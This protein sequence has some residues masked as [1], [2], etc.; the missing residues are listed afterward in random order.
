METN[1]N[2]LLEWN[3][4]RKLVAESFE[5]AAQLLMLFHTPVSRVV[6]QYFDCHAI[7]S[8]SS[9]QAFLRWDYS[10]LCWTGSGPSQE[11]DFRYLAFTSIVLLVLFAFTLALPAFFSG[12]LIVKRNELYSPLVMGR[13]GWLYDRLNR[14]CEFWE[15]HEMLRKMMLTGV[16][17]FFPSHPVIRSALAIL[18][19][20]L[21]IVNLNYFKPHRS[22]LVFWTE[23][24]SFALA[25]F[26][27]V[28]AII[29]STDLAPS[30]RES[31]GIISIAVL[32]TFW[33]GMVPV[34][35]G[36]FVILARRLQEPLKQKADAELHSEMERVER[37]LSAMGAAGDT[38]V[39]PVRVGRV[40]SGSQGTHNINRF[41]RLSL[42]AMQR[43][44][45]ERT[46]AS[47]AIS[48]AK[49]VERLDRQRSSA[50]ARLQRRKMN[51]TT[52]SL[53][54]TGKATGTPR[55]ARPGLQRGLTSIALNTGGFGTSV[56]DPDTD[57]D[58]N[59]PRHI[60]QPMKDEYLSAKAAYNDAGGPAGTDTAVK[61]R[62]AR[63]RKTLR[64]AVEAEEA[65]WA[66]RD[67][68][69]AQG[70]KDDAGRKRGLLRSDSFIFQTLAA[71][72]DDDDEEDTDG[73]EERGGEAT[74]GTEEQEDDD[75]HAREDEEGSAFAKGYLQK[76]GI[77]KVRHKILEKFDPGGVTGVVKIKMLRKLLVKLKV[78]D[79]DAAIWNMEAMA[80]S[81]TGGV[82]GKLLPTA[83]FL[84]WCGL[85]EDDDEEGRIRRV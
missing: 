68:Q 3:E 63:A 31:L 79:P 16:I 83:A 80:D 35:I 20:I 11:W 74:D 62:F 72:D 40:G 52:S 53:T 26:L 5:F 29:A 50:A 9:T 59:L 45:N 24:F 4:N 75:H 43:N 32:A 49:R 44:H 54:T 13:I 18:I 82:P 23:Q 39:T 78:E 28:V 70:G 25:L 55:P 2:A 77:A 36:T 51:R 17:I 81:D 15:V 34:I 65:E 7:G 69:T 42:E 47:H 71:S 22:K 6:F 76:C 58:A 73:G 84:R 56:D 8:G 10:V 67:N 27:Y 1:A 37:N 12:F 14:G 60:T 57:G 19:C 30:T 33:A 85:D 64:E 21:A 46:L 48:L 41:R 61:T 66:Q 38:K